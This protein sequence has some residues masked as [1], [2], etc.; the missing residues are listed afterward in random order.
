MVNLMLSNIFKVIMIFSL[1]ISPLLFADT[2]QMLNSVAKEF[3][4]EQNSQFSGDLREE[5]SSVKAVVKEA[6]I[7]V[8]E[9]KNIS[10][11]MQ[12]R[13]SK[14]LE[15]GMQSLV[16][17]EI[18]H[19]DL[20]AAQEKFKILEKDYNGLEEK[21]QKTLEVLNNF[22]GKKNSTDEIAILNSKVKQLTISM[23]KA[24]ADK[25]GFSSLLARIKDRSL[26]QN[27]QYTNLLR[28]KNSLA[29]KVVYLKKRLKLNNRN[30]DSQKNQKSL[31]GV[32]K[33]LSQEKER[34]SKLEKDLSVSR[35]ET[36]LLKRHVKKLNG[37]I[38]LV[39]TR[40]T[41]DF[42]KQLLER[43]ER[44]KILKGNGEQLQK[45]KKK[46]KQLEQS[47][48]K[49]NV[50]TKIVSFASDK[51]DYQKETLSELSY[52]VEALASK[53][54]LLE[55]Q[56]H[57][58]K[59]VEDQ[60]LKDQRELKIMIG[61]YRQ[62]QMNH[63]EEDLRSK[64]LIVEGETPSVEDEFKIK[65]LQKEN[66]SFKKEEEKQQ[67]RQLKNRYQEELSA[68]KVQ[69]M[70]YK[71][72]LQDKKNVKKEPVTLPKNKTK[73]RK[74]KR[75]LEILLTNARK[76]TNA[77]K[78]K[79]TFFM[80]ELKRLRAKFRTEVEN[81]LQKKNQ[82]LLSD[83]RMRDQKILLIESENKSL[84]EVLSTQQSL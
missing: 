66:D 41:E 75:D 28:E 56:Q 50:V 27:Q 72:K 17:L 79:M 68:L 20:E 70:S 31:V 47:L 37:E 71:T 40:L 73:S 2:N 57:N 60:L 10:Q 38:H 11:E 8:Q 82:T 36:H 59:Q 24:L 42:E 53:N 29:K 77:Y 76:S 4:Y 78:K 19:S 23:Q 35:K 6:L 15:G 80:Q 65:N 51:K 25:R 81:P 69:L 9:D 44:I 52:Y 32:V 1:M 49:K 84:R 7:E 5:R 46:I 61:K 63:K 62:M 67:W 83:L 74:E 43:E 54:Q 48:A 13:V 3:S 45:F 33:E 64:K 30:A 39:E 21:Y 16:R 14:A 26:K 12:G 55:E 22:R 18:R 34:Y 58:K